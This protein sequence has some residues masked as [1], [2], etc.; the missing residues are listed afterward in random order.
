MGLSEIVD[1]A[2]SGWHASNLSVN[3]QWPVELSVDSDNSETLLR[4]QVNSVIGDKH[5][6]TRI[7]NTSLFYTQHMVI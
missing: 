3:R 2:L 7:I 4:E 6:I 5:N 1:T